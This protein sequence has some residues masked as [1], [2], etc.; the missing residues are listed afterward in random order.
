M[1]SKFTLGFIAGATA[2][3]TIVVAGLTT[4]K[5]AI[6]NPIERREDWIEENRKKANRK[7]ISR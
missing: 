3:L 1:K 6:I 2:A 7:R 5:L 4:V